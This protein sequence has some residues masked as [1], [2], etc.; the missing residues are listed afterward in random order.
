MSTVSG[1]GTSPFFFFFFFEGLSKAKPGDVPLK[2][3]SAGQ[4]AG[5]INSNFVAFVC[6][7]INYALLHA[8]ILVSRD[9]RSHGA[10][11]TGKV[12][13]GNSGKTFFAAT[14]LHLHSADSY[15][16]WKL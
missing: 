13:W 1:L 2:N 5:V 6:F 11:C 3:I 10:T 7:G 8:C 9:R 12:D 4:S 15:Q 14:Y 16:T